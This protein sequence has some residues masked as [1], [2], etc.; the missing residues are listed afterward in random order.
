MTALNL[1]FGIELEFICVRPGDFTDGLSATADTGTVGPAIYSALLKNRVPATGWEDLDDPINNENDPPSHSRW[2]VETDVLELSNL[3]ET[4]LP[5]GWIAEAVELSSRKFHFLLDDWRGEIAKIIKVLRDVEA[6][7]CRFITN[8][9]TGFH[10]HVGNGIQRIPLRTAKNVFQLVTSFERCFDEVHTVPRIR[11]P[12]EISG[13]HPCYPPSFW[14]I[15]NKC[16]ARTVYDRLANI[17]DFRSY[18]DLG[19]FF[20]VPIPGF[21][22]YT[23][24]GHNSA[25]NFENLYPDAEADRH[26]E[27][28][29]G[30]IEFRQHAGTL[31]FIEIVAWVLLTCQAVQYAND[32]Q[33]ADFLDLLAR[34]ADPCI[35]L[36]DLL[37]AM[38]VSE[39]VIDHYFNKPIIGII[40]D[41]VAPASRD[42]RGARAITELLLA[43]ND[44]EAED[45]SDQAAVKAAI[46]CKFRHGNYG[47]DPRFPS[48]NITPGAVAVELRKALVTVQMSGVDVRTERGLSKARSVVLR[49]LSCRYRKAKR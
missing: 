11:I 37:I 3:E 17:D 47:L 20:E 31:D 41:G 39:D 23:I 26:E 49:D 29:T 35:R 38:D 16:N 19:G 34:S 1:T 25:Y 45:G 22:G 15:H 30:T 27:N 44:T 28:L 4:H 18:E 24:A 32:T 12:N 8:Q 48:A 46:D 9:S 5:K 6:Y 36:H 10:V 42:R 14:H 2:R 40:G 13:G 33:P 21:N 43:Q 7:G